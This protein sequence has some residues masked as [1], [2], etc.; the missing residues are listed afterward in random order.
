MKDKSSSS[1]IDFSMD[2]NTNDLDGE[3]GANEEKKDTIYLTIKNPKTDN[4]SLK[5]YI[6]DNIENNQNLTQE[7]L[8]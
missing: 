8:K 6:G 1:D 2:K 3:L 5:F 7:S 4:Y